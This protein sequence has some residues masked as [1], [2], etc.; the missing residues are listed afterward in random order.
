MQHHIKL[1]YLNKIINPLVIPIAE[2]Y[3]SQFRE[4]MEKALKSGRIYPSS[5]SQASA[6]FCVPKP[7]KP[8][9]ARFVTDFRAR[10]Q[11]TVKDRYPLPHIPTILNRLAKAKYRS[12]VDLTPIFKSEST[13]QTYNT[14]LNAVIQHR[15]SCKHIWIDAFYVS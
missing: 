4:K 10:N 15:P 7:G 11:N 6:M 2:K 8:H 3:Y 14:A 13:L 1:I 9:I 5:S 12:K